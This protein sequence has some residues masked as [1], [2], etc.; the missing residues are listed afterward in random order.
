[1]FGTRI[2]NAQ[3]I[4]MIEKEK[5]IALRPFDRDRLRLAHYALNPGAV[6]E[7]GRIGQNGRR[8][9]RKLHDFDD[10][11]TFVLKPHQYVL[12][13]IKEFIELEDGLSADFVAP[14]NLIVNGFGMSAGKLDAG[15]ASAA[16]KG[17]RLFVQVGLENKLDVDNE[18]HSDYGISYLAVTDYRG[19]KSAPVDFSNS[20]VQEFLHQFRRWSRAKDDGPD[21][22]G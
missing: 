11:P 4:S 8:E 16:G 19:L 13:Q 20:E 3:F 18:Y 6:L 9:Y 7:L 17:Q 1:M 14:S 21:Y 10:G 2:S 15:F 22:D 12:I 5:S